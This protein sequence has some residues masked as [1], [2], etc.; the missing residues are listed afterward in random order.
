MTVDAYADEQGRVRTIGQD[1][2]LGAR[3]SL[4]RWSGLRRA[5]RWRRSQGG[6]GDQSASGKG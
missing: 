2:R 4:A 6:R 3:R 5:G 1:N